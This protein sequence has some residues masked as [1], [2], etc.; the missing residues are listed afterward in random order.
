[1]FVFDTFGLR[2]GFA[3]G[4]D[5]RDASEVRGDIAYVDC[6]SMY[7]IALEEKGFWGFHAAFEKWVPFGLVFGD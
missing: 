6:N 1:M 7:K 4:A 2:K 3:D 5:V